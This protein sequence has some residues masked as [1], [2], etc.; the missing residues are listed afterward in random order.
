MKTA[1]V[2]THPFLAH[3]LPEIQPSLSISC[4]DDANFP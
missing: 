2:K 4:T 1:T 3:K